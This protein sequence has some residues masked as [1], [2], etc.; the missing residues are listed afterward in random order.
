MKKKFFKVSNSKFMNHGVV[1]WWGE[2]SM[3]HLNC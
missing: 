1:E 2:V 3:N